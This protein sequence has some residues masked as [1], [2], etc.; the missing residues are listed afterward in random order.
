MWKSIIGFEG[1]YEVSEH[2]EVKSL[3]RWHRNGTTGYFTK[4]VILKPRKETKGYF[5]YE[6]TRG[7]GTSKNFRRSRLIAIHFIPNPNNLPQVNHKN[8]IKTDDSISNL[9]W[10]TPSENEK[11]AYRTGLK[12]A[13]YFGRFGKDHNQSKPVI[14][15]NQTA[16]V[17]FES[18]TECGKYFNVTVQAVAQA[19]KKNFECRGHH[20]YVL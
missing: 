6:L 17:E 2:G 20:I 18:K 9:E 12:K 5:H 14:A 16:I 8:G 19:I 1:R 15:I 3:S 10:C 11:H 13:A 7:D 4:E